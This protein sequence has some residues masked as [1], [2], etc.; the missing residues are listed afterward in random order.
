MNDS[1]M[2]TMQDRNIR[3]ALQA[4]KDDLAA[5]RKD[6]GKMATGAGHAIKESGASAYE[7]VQGAAKSS[8]AATEAGFSEHP[9][10]SVLI[11]FGAG[12]VVSKLLSK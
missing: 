11:A 3:Q 9:W 4:V 5:L 7:S 2:E 10:T 12:I 1:A 8:I 6:V